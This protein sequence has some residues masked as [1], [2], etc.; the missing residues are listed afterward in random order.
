MASVELSTLTTANWS[1]VAPVATQA[2]LDAAVIS[3]GG[4]AEAS[5]ADMAAATDSGKRVSPRRMPYSVLH[6]SGDTTGATDTA[7]LNAL[8]VPRQVRL[9]PG[10][11][12][13]VNATIRTGLHIQ[14]AGREVTTVVVPNSSQGQA[15]LSENYGTLAGTDTG[16][17]P[18]TWSIT[19]LTIDA[20]GANNATASW[21]IVTYGYDFAIERVDIY[22]GRLGGILSEWSST[23]LGPD[24]MA[25]RLNDVKTWTPYDAYGIAWNGPHDSHW[26]SVSS[27][28]T[29]VSN[30][31]SGWLFSAKSFGTRLTQSH[32]WGYHAWAAIVDGSGTWFN[33]CYLEGGQT[34]QLYVRAADGQYLGGWVYGNDTAGA[35]GIELGVAAGAVANGWLIDTRVVNCRGGAVGLVNQVSNKVR[36]HAS[37]NT[38]PT[39]VTTG[40]ATN[41][42]WSDV[43]IQVEN[44]AAGDEYQQIRR[45]ALFHNR[46]TAAQPV[47]ITKGHASQSAA[48]QSWRTSGDVEVASVTTAGGFR[49]LQVATGS[50]PTAASAGVGA[51]IY[52]TTLSKPIWSNG[53]V[54]KDAAGTTV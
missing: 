53:T 29:L 23:V 5:A 39:A 6:P 3:G 44:Y 41:T 32:V 54:W 45:R 50:R 16:G 25:A 33:Q 19:D 37:F 43:D 30:S 18:C 15:F 10:T 46:S 35:K 11:F 49:P 20:N 8:S 2:E 13:M 52:D 17:G 14:G 24:P 31:K 4:S 9:A 22:N 38:A 21:G 26:T 47:I 1:T 28:S 42:D 40:S 27:M 51:M 12:Y 36:I 34:G 48:M 7:A